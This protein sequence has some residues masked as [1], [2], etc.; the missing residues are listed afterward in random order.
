[1]K[2]IKIGIIGSGGMARHHADRFSS[3]ATTEVVAIASRNE[4]TG[5]QL[6]AKHATTFISDWKRLVERDDIDG[7]VIC[8]HNNSHGEIAIAVLQAD[9]HVFVEYPL[10]NDVNEGAETLHLAKTH[11]RVLRVSHPEVVSNIHAALK[12]KTGELGEL[13]LTSFVRLTHGRGARPEIL[14][15]LSVSGTPAH[16][17]IYHIYPIVDLFGEAKWVEGAAC[18]EGLT[19]SGQYNRFV[20]SVTVAF[21]QGGIGQWSWA[22]GIAINTA[23]Q[24]ARYVLT[25]GTLSDD[26]SGWRCS[27]PNGVTELTIPKTPQPTLQELW[28]SEIQNA[29]QHAPCLADA[30]VAL[31]A[32][33]ISL[34]SAQAIRE[35]RR[36]EL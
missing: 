19:E 13:L 26:G 29:T 24:H 27:T 28:L 34:A 30:E 2:N 8:T 5:I 21:K 23:E 7:I 4:Q 33:R 11:H 16:F 3:I 12:Q 32:I 10:A 14:F 15:N 17:F 36:I 25:E 1:M 6:A 18:Y 20:N 22:G 9:K 35:N 31:S